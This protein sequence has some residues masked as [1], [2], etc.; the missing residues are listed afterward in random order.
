MNRTETPNAKVMHVR[1]LDRS[2]LP[3]WFEIKDDVN[4]KDKKLIRDIYNESNVE[5]KEEYKRKVLK[6]TG[7]IVIQKKI[8]L[9]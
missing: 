1:D 5:E 8:M 3:D 2:F 6:H 7:S 4:P 9:Q